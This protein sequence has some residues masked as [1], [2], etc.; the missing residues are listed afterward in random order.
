MTTELLALLRVGDC[1]V[2]RA[3]RDTDSL[4]ADGRSCVF[5]GGQ[6]VLEPGAGFTDDAVAGDSAV[7]E[8][9]PGG[10]RAV[11]P[12]FA[13][14][15]PTVKPSSSRCIANAEIPLAPFA[16]S[17][18]AIT[19]YQEALPPFDIQHFAPLKTHSSPASWARVFIA[20]ASLPASRSERA[21]AASASPEASD[22]KT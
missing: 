21:Y 19:V 6:C 9:Q 17:V 14:L 15:A 1:L 16:G 5:K 8:V 22:G 18:T 10:R 11:E 3:L 2:Q 12:E 20:A 7:L 13:F 4:G